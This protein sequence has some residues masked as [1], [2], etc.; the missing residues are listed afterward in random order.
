MAQTRG[1]PWVW[2]FADDDLTES[3]CIRAFHQAVMEDERAGRPANVYRFNTFTIDDYD[4]II[5][6]NPPHPERETGAAF[7]Y[8]KLT[9]ARCSYAPE[10]VFARAAF[11]RCGGFVEFPF[12]MGSDDASWISFAEDM[13]LRTI[14]GS[15]VRWRLGQTNTSRLAGEQTVE[16][17]LAVLDYTLWLR[18]RF[19]NAPPL[20]EPHGA[21]WQPTVAAVAA[22]Y[23]FHLLGNADKFL[24]HREANRLVVEIHRR[25]GFSR[26]YVRA[27][28]YQSNWRYVST[29][30]RRRARRLFPLTPS[31]AAPGLAASREAT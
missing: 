23:F 7:I 15:N 28:V 14:P 8:H 11:E 9:G 10:H 24:S 6:I 31:A 21:P 12:A 16:K 22:D 25:S 3:G 20:V 2:L 26:R 19:A 29:A 1:E 30:W 17:L 27:K 13:P 5:R 4:A 18:R